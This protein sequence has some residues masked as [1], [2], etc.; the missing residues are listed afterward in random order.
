L[1][2]CGATQEGCQPVLHQAHLT[3]HGLKLFGCLL[4]CAQHR[5]LART[6][7]VLLEL[8]CK[9]VSLLLAIM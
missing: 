8:S 9:A 5:V 2:L 3:G 7:P 6:E 4:D 1:T